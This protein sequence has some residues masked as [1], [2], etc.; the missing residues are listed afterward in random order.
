MDIATADEIADQLTEVTD[1][2]YRA[3]SQLEGSSKKNNERV[4]RNIDAFA[5]CDN[6]VL[7]S[8]KMLD[9]GIDVP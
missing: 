4:Q 9:E 6:G 7:V 8:P 5:Q 2:V 1:N 3:H